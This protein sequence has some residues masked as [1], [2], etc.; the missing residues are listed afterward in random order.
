MNLL[1]TS[2]GSELARTVAE[3]LADRH[4]LRLTDRRD[5]RLAGEFAVSPLGH[6]ASTSL[7]V[8][9]MDAIV[10]AGEP[11]PAD[12]GQ[13][14]LDTMTRGTYNLLLAASQ[15]GVRRVVYLSTLDLMT[16]YAPEYNVTERWRPRPAPEPRLLGKYLGEAVCR[17]F[18]REH[19]LMVVVLRIGTL[20]ADD[21]ATQ[22]LHP[23]AIVRA[24]VALAVEQ[25]LTAEV[26]PWTVFH[27]QSEFPGARFAIGDA[28]RV[29][30]FNP[31]ALGATQKAGGA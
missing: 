16:A 12:S 26:K 5:Y 14:Y 3:G 4:T 22:T 23:Q 8:R 11:D 7:L 18:A 10:H 24:D 1:I 21:M 15:E 17:E 2:A 28:K 20:A 19:K 30:G 29:L 31:T 6:D 27:V 9:G 13:D 25:A